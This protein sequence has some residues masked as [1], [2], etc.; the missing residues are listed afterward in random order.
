MSGR[1]S[2]ERAWKWY[3]ARAWPCGFN[4]VP[5]SAI[6][7][8]QMWLADSFDPALIDSE[9][10]LAR[11]I[12]LN[13]ARVVLPFVVWEAEPDAFLAR[14]ETFVQLCA[15][16]G[17]DVMPALFDDCTFGL[18]TD[19]A[20]G[21]QPDVIEGWYA[22]GWTPSP[23]HSMVRDPSTWRRLERY[24]EAVIG[25]FAA[26]PRIFVWDLYNEPTNSGVGDATLPLLAK[27]IE[28]AR[29][30]DPPQPLTIGRWNES[31]A[32]N[33][34]IEANVDIETFHD[35]RSPEALAAGIANLRR[36]GRP[37]ICTEWLNRNTGSNVEGCL[38]VF[39][40]ERVGCMLWGIVN[41]RTQTDLNWGHRPGD[42]PPP[43]WQ[44]DLFRGDHTPYDPAELELFARAIRG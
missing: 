20:F 7:Y 28:W 31:P 42:P 38:R 18:I 23:G 22:S 11:G 8:T 9:L 44:C 2:P 40:D 41:G 29:E 17:I 4:Y 26:D 33:A 36:Q 13:C 39:R 37:M 5:A 27:V 25:R 21:P 1:W 35:Y 43:R 16:R 19:P 10:A 32:L 24:V 3:D 15:D 14:L 12:G 6:S 30:I 34:V